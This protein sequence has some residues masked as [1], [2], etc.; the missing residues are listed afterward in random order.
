MAPECFFFAL[1]SASCHWNHIQ[2]C[3]PVPLLGFQAAGHVGR[4]K[5]NCF[6][7][8]KS[9]NAQE[10]RGKKGTV[11]LSC[12]YQFITVQMNQLIL[13]F[14]RGLFFFFNNVSQEMPKWN[15]IFLF[16]LSVFFPGWHSRKS[17]FSFPNKKSYCA[18]SWLVEHTYCCISLQVLFYD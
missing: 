17:L 10:D 18:K 15:I 6:D 9:I 7:L 14:K 11:L 5:L 12:Y 1:S 16:F 3:Q 4:A 2:S 13:H 8:D